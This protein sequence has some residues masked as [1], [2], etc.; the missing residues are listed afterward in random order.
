MDFVNET[1]LTAAFARGSTSDREMVGVVAAKLT[2]RADNARMTVCTEDDAWPVFEA[3]HAI[4][5]VTLGAEMDFRKQGT[6][7]I[8][9]GQAAAPRQQPCER[10]RV[11]I[12]C[13]SVN[14][15]VEV[16]GDRW[17]QK[18]GGDM[19][20]TDPRPFVTM[21][22]TN[23]RAFGGVG[24]H[25]GIQVPHAV[26]PIGRGFSMSPAD[27]EGKPMPNIERPA[28]LI[29][30]C[31]DR[32]SP[33][34]LYR[35]H[36][37]DINAELLTKPPLEIAAHLLENAGNDAVPDLIAPKGQLGS[38]LRLRGFDPWGDVVFPLP[39][40]HGPDVVVRVGAQRSRF[41]A[42]IATVI[43]LVETRVLVVTYRCVF[44]YLFQPGDVRTARLV[45]RTR[46]ERQA[47]T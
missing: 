34:C 1:P 18:V 39:P 15:E 42:T 28:S 43:A 30:S 20:P 8:V 22:L 31:T 6:D 27:A 33:A 3:A 26:N 47:Q 7:I 2:A 46:A 32:P 12:H 13:G 40:F 35:P 17:W 11:G 36:A 44:R 9:L 10:L 37:P 41:P 24:S 4:Q 23:D 45:W 19:V 14:F 29:R 21:P 25:D 38:E 5:G 16:F